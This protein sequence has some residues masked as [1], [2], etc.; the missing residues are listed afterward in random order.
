MV[1]ALKIINKDL[2]KGYIEVLIENEDDLWILYNIIEQ[3]DIITAKTTREIKFSDKSSRRVSM[4]VSIKVK[5]LEFQPFTDRLRLRGII[6]EGPEKYGVKGKHHTLN[7]APGSKIIIWKN[8]WF[9]H[10]LDRII[11]ASNIKTR[12]LLVVLDYDES[13]FALLGEQGVKILNEISSYLP[14]KDSPKDFAIYL[15][16]YFEEIAEHIIKFVEQYK[17]EVAVIAGPGDIGKRVIKILNERKTSLSKVYYDSVSIG[18][19]NGLNELLRRDSVKKAVEE[20]SIIKA[21]SIVDEFKKL[22]IK[23]PLLVAYGFDDV[24]YAVQHNAVEKLVVSSDLIR[25]YDEELRKQVN[26]VVEEAY[27]RK[28]EI[29]IVPHNSDIGKEVEGFGGIIA[30]LRYPLPRPSN[31]LKDA[32]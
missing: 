13:C 7:I 4:T 6:I 14:G 32:L 31:L 19:C 10:Q 30:I 16:K 25:C 9:K 27:R 29:V 12:I 26:I 20:I 22:L 17:V 23:D 21:Q 2:K 5:N 18:G 11:E 8:T 3:G 28:A 15:N 1:L 24:K